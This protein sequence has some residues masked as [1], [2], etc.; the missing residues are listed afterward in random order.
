MRCRRAWYPHGQVPPLV[1]GL[2]RIEY[3]Y[4]FLAFEHA[5]SSFSVTPQISASSEAK[6]TSSCQ[7]WWTAVMKEKCGNYRSWVFIQPD[8]H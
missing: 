2:G 1:A 3:G 7:Y 8:H 5:A 4:C 6:N